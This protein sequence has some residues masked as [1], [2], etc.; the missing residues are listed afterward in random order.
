MTATPTETCSIAAD[1]GLILGVTVGTTRDVAMRR[2]YFDC[3]LRCGCQVSA[4]IDEHD[5]MGRSSDATV[6]DVVEALVCERHPSHAAGFDD[7]VEL[8]GWAT[9]SEET[10]SSFRVDGETAHEARSGRDDHD[11]GD[12]AA[13]GIAAGIADAVRA[14]GQGTR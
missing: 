7:V 2:F 10:R 14:A 9:V 13:R 11:A 12:R 3:T 6:D 8:G 5:L 1:V 4:E